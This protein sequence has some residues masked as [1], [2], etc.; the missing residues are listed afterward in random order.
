MKQL[1]IALPVQYKFFG[2][3]KPIDAQSFDTKLEDFRQKAYAE[4]PEEHSHLRGRCLIDNGIHAIK[5]LL[6]NLW[7]NREKLALVKWPVIQAYMQ[8]DND[9]SAYAVS[10]LYR[11]GLTVPPQY[12]TAESSNF[13]E[14]M[15]AEK[16]E[17]FH[18]YGF[19]E[20]PP[21]QYRVKFEKREA[22][23]SEQQLRELRK[24]QPDSFIDVVEEVKYTEVNVD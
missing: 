10:I 9:Y 5:T 4:M 3:P 2:G 19:K 14:A 22:I 8:V 13:A 15:Q 20:L 1:H 17:I 21:K 24:E 6:R 11:E 23:L 7:K 12:D 18:K 16:D